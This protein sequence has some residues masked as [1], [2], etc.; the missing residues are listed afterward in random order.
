M[1]LNR[2]IL[3]GRLASDPEFQAHAEWHSGKPAFASP[4]TG[5]CPLRPARAGR[6]SRPTFSALSPGV[7]Q[8]NMPP[9][10]SAKAV[11]SPWKAAF[12]CVNMSPRPEK[13]GADTEV[14]VDNLKSLDRPE[15]R[16]R[17][18]RRQ[19]AVAIMVARTV[20]AITTAAAATIM[21]AAVRM[22]TKRPPRRLPARQPAPA[23]AQAAPAA[24]PGGSARPARRWRQ[25]RQLSGTCRRRPRRSVCRQ[26]D[27]SST[28]IKPRP[29]RMAG[30]GFFAG[31]FK[32][33]LCPG[34]H[35]SWLHSGPSSPSE[36]RRSCE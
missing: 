32:A 16:R 15:R 1:D 19:W 36:P 2:V 31:S 13:N 21:T 22:P 26:L 17:R 8:R 33:A 9:I 4:S 29:A 23:R 35:R 7:S 12:K 20:V 34:R 10:I 28:I 6:K 30:R 24:A 18:R 3:I 25:S 11:W 14:V 27:P 5:P